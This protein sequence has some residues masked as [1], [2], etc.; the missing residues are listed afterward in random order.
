M[1]NLF[2][3]KKRADH[4]ASLDAGKPT[5]DQP[6]MLQLMWREIYQDKGALVA[7]IVFLGILI[8]AFIVAANID[9]AQARIVDIRLMNQ[10]PSEN[11]LLGTDPGGRS[12]V[13]QLFLGA[14][15]S[16]IIA[17]VVTIVSSFIGIVTG[18]I[19]G[20]KGGLVDNVMMRVIDFWM[21]LP[22][23]MI[24]IAILS[25]IGAYDVIQFSFIFILFS[26]TGTARLI[27]SKTLQQSELDYVAASKTLGTPNIIV[28]L[29]EVFPNLIP[30]VVV[31]L[32]IT[33]AA[34][35]GVET[36]LTALGF[37]LPFGTSS[38]GTLVAYAL[39]P[40]TLVGRPWQWLPAS[41]TIFVMMFCVYYIGQAISRSVDVKRRRAV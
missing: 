24:I 2:N 21:M 7:L 12:M 19:A 30:I 18:L 27:R 8:S 14:R 3:S 33:L 40:Q 31:N 6:T 38:L 1:S 17:F 36:G 20:F 39:N 22:S 41:F 5:T 29:R 16:F 15:N 4:L 25:S 9:A 23:L 35:M 26:W 11:F 37:G 34:N 10:P 13:Q 32:T 28:M